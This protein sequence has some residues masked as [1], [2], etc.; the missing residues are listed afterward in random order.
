MG[1]LI[2]ETK[3]NA[4]SYL[5]RAGRYKL[6]MSAVW[7][8]SSFLPVRERIQSLNTTFNSTICTLYDISM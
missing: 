3:K 1:F 5:L 8:V 4:F 7:L 2:T 6:Q